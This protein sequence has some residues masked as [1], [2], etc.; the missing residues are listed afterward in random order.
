MAQEVPYITVKT[1]IHKKTANIENLTDFQK[2]LG[3]PVMKKPPVE[4]TL[5]IPFPDFCTIYYELT[6]W[7]QFETQMNE[8]LE[9]IFYNYDH[10]DSFVM[11]SEYDNATKKGNGYR[12]VGFRDGNI[13]PKNNIEEFSNQERILKHTYQIKVPTYLILDPKDETLAYGRKHGTSKTDDNS[14]Y[15]YKSQNV[16]DIKLEEKVL[17]A[18]QFDELF[19]K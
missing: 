12:F 5:T 7:T 4:E 18:Q 17:S 10:L 14:K 15:V 8:I 3:F 2:K 1:N 19:K 13:T 16:V 6:I 9:K 11:W